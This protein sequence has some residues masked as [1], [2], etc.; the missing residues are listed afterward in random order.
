MIIEWI[1][2]NQNVVLPVA[3]LAFSISLLSYGSYKGHEKKMS[4]FAKGIIS[5]VGFVQSIVSGTSDGTVSIFNRYIYLIDVEKENIELKKLLDEERKRNNLL[6]EQE[7]ENARLRRL[8]NFKPTEKI[9]NI[10][11]AQVIGSILGSNKTITINKGK[12][13]GIL[14]GMA[15]ISYDSALIG[16]ILDEPGSV[17]GPYHS[18]VLLINDRRSRVDV[19]VQ[20]A[21]SRAHGIVA[22]RPDTG[23]CEM[24]YAD[25]LADITIGDTL[26]S[27]GYGGVFNKGWPLGIVSSVIHD[28]SMFYTKIKVRPK[29]DFSRLEE[30]MVIVPMEEE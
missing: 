29:A 13:D 9:K 7:I 16:Q 6:R 3:L 4:V 12:R 18:Q 14:P 27:S 17:I 19:M 8:L 21:E 20:R 30:V 15:V 22:G 10:I 24:L 11:P 5:A 2:R 1:R 23:E 28:S 26:I 25:R